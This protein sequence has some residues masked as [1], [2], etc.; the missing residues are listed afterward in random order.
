MSSLWLLRVLDLGLG[1][2]P[3]AQDGEIALVHN[4]KRMAQKCRKSHKSIAEQRYFD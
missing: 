3:G 2:G 4:G 1:L